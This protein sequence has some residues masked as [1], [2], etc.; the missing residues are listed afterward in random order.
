MS[1]ACAV[2]VRGLLM[3]AG[4]IWLA[5]CQGPAPKVEAPAP[6]GP[7][8]VQLIEPAP[9]LSAINEQPPT[10]WQLQILP[11]LSD[12]ALQ[13]PALRWQPLPGK[14]LPAISEHLR[15]AQDPPAQLDRWLQPAIAASGAQLGSADQ[16]PEQTTFLLQPHLLEYALQQ[17]TN[18]HWQVLIQADA[19]LFS[20]D[21]GERVTQKLF[22]SRIACKD[23][24]AQGISAAYSAALNT[25][26]QAMVDWTL[27]EGDTLNYSE[28][29]DTDPSAPAPALNH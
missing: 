10:Q 14:P 21:S 13:T 27:R 15:W 29:I 24:N 26:L 28:S 12:T 1:R 25:L 18:G 22:E 11:T 7:P 9:N 2:D 6:A 5:G 4:L 19:R 16:P 20:P 3:F 23:L 17:Q 8:P